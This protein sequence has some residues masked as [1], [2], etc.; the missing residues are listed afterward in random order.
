[1][2]VPREEYKAAWNK[3]AKKVIAA[4]EKKGLT[5]NDLAR[6]AGCHVTAVMNLESGEKNPA[7]MRKWTIVPICRVLDLNIKDII[8]TPVTVKDYEKKIRKDI[9]GQVFG[10]LTVLS[11][12]RQKVGT[13]ET[14][15]LCRCACGKEVIAKRT[16]L[17]SG[18]RSSCGCMRREKAV[19]SMKQVHET[20]IFEGRNLTAMQQSRANSNNR[21]T[22]M[23]GV[24]YISTRKVFVAYLRAN[25]HYF[26]KT[27][28]ILEDAIEYRKYLE[29]TY[30]KP[31][32]E[33]YEVK[34]AQKKQSELAGEQMIE[35]LK[36]KR[37]RLGVKTKEIALAAGRKKPIICVSRR[38]RK[39]QDHR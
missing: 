32:L 30:S 16:V 17:V 27:F 5:Q 37:K 22:G 23:R 14:Y 1:M 31:V 38:K 25:G 7:N 19:Q 8:T 39:D 15:W 20:T 28:R 34:V 4:R 36:E 29:E 26:S 2:A 13:G 35:K 3:S 10:Q 11:L 24:S 33:R 21:S 12:H 9:T 6:M 18:S